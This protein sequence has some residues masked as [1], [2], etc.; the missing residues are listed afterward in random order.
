MDPQTVDLIAAV[1]R[2]AKDT[3][4]S[5]SL[6]A[7]LYA[8]KAAGIAALFGQHCLIPMHVSTGPWRLAA[9]LGALLPTLRP[10]Q[11]LNL[12]AALSEA[13]QQ[14][15]PLSPAALLDNGLPLHRWPVPNLRQDSTLS[16]LSASQRSRLD[17]RGSWLVGFSVPDGPGQSD[18]W[19]DLHQP[20]RLVESWTDLYRL[21]TLK[22]ERLD[23]NG[24]GHRPDRAF[25]TEFPLDVILAKLNVTIKVNKH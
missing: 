10:E 16:S 18:D 8:L 21:P 6:R 5:S 3:S 1:S 9:D 13:E 22:Q 14:G 19:C 17:P 12:G 4:L 11:A 25:K 20:Y 24:Y 2:H 23:I 7:Q 15:T